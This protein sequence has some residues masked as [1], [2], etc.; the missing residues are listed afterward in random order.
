MHLLVWLERAS[1][2]IDPTDVDDLISA[3]IPDPVLDPDLHATVTTSMIH[4]PCGPNHPNSPC[5]DAEK[6]ICTKGYWPLKPWCNETVMVHN[7][8]PQ[9]R[10]R[11]QGHT[12]T[13]QANGQ[14]VVLDNRNVVPYNPYL[15]RRYNCH[16]NVETCSGINAIKYIFKYVYKGHDRAFVVF[17]QRNPNNRD[18][19]DEIKLHLDARWIS[20]Y[21]ALWRIF[22]FAL[23]REVPNIY[24]LQVHL[25]NQETVVFREGQLLENIAA[26]QVDTKLTAF[27]KLN[28]QPLAAI[29]AIANNML[30]QE[31]PNKFSWD[32]R[33]R[34]W[35]LRRTK[36]QQAWAVGGEPEYIGGAIGRMYFVGPNGGPRFF[37]RLLLTVVR[38]PTSFENLRSYQGILHPTY[39]VACI[40]RGIVESD[41]EWAACLTEASVVQTGRQLRK[42][43]VIILTACG[44]SDPMKLWHDYCHHI[45]DDLQYYMEHQPWAPADLQDNDI[46]DYGLYL[47]QQLVEDAG[48]S[49]ERVHMESCQ[50]N[51]AQFGE[52][53]R[54]IQEQLQLARDQPLGAAEDL[55]A[56][57]NQEQR[58]A[59]NQ[60]Y[61]SVTEEQGRTF[62]LDGPA[63][64]GKTFLY[65]A[66]C[67]KL[68]AEGQIVLCVASSGIAS[69][70]LPGGRTS[71][72]RFKLPLDIHETSTCNISKDSDLGK[73]IARTKLIIWDEVPMQ[74][75]FC[76]EAF[77]RTSKDL[78]SN[79]EKDF[80]GITVVFGGDFR[81]ILPVIPH[82]EPEQIMAACLKRSDL[83]P[84]MN[85]LYLTQNMRLQGDQEAADFAAWLLRLGEGVDIAEGYSGTVAFRPEM[86]VCS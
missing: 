33:L 60:I 9:Y 46:Y 69:L 24:R 83:W 44:P 77:N 17:G 70:L 67:Y 63:G 16:I 66:L 1:H 84:R 2:I 35:K 18:R 34:T 78:C 45:C 11:D 86:L 76:A 71:H 12:T 37:L 62:F 3:E 81:Q 21:E 85:K 82:G 7:S 38:G 4:G 43:F 8:Y 26:N 48:F 40:A 65:K 13:K 59:F 10:R 28:T 29:R 27:F 30:Y 20:P 80:G 25:E 50:S 57:L 23:H 22:A 68:R 32:Q 74:H 72:S 53:N 75:R 61:E 73:L 5:W 6:Q 15:S 36:A 56:Q 49:M 55:E 39:Q 19:P 41:E 14:N 47:V 51:W 58:A 42:L 52:E 79:Q 64:T 54:L 31:I